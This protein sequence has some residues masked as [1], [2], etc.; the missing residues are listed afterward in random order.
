METGSVVIIF[1]FLIIFCFIVYDSIPSK[2]AKLEES[3]GGFM[4]RSLVRFEYEKSPL[5]TIVYGGTGTGKT[6]FVRQYLQLYSVQNQDPRSGYNDQDQNQNQG[7]NQDQDQNQDQNQ[8]QKQNQNLRSSLVNHEQSSFTD[9]D[10]NIVIVCKDDRDWINP[11]T[12]KFY[13]GF[14]KCDMNMITKNNMQKFRNCVIVLDDMGDKLNKDIDYYFTEGRHYNI[15]MIVM[16]HKPAQINN[17]ARMSCDTIYL[18][19]YNGSDLFKNFNEIYKCEHDFSKII[20]EL[21]SN[22]YNRTDG[23]SDELRYGII[24]YNKKENTF[25]I[26]NSNRTMIY[27]SRVGFLDLKA[28]SLKDELGREDINKLIAY[29]KPLMIN[30]T[31]RNTISHDNYQFYFNKHLTLKGIKI[32]NDVLT[33]EVVKANGLRLFSTILGI[34]SSGL[35]IYNFMSPDITVRNAGHVATAASTMLN[36]TSTLLNYGFGRNQDQDQ[37]L[38]QEREYTDGETWSKTHQ[39]SCYTDGETWTKSYQRSSYTHKYTGILNKEGRENLNSLYVNNEEFRNEIINY[40]KNKMQLNLEAILDK[41]CKTN[42]LNT[43]GNKY[44]AEC[45]KSKD[46]TKDVIEILAKYIC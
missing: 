36:R 24:K 3:F 31:D 32:Q 43:L 5:H 22:H 29:M 45:I 34:I 9:Q 23:M 33:Q 2:Y 13:T 14:N 15:Q 26:I 28:L 12:N 42:I 40:V 10:Q 8:D 39:R 44:L 1:I 16:C 18:T 19:T 20:N 46:N 41:R 27:D 35:M 6:Y 4:N 21:N 7:Q 38:E 30:A 37:D 11:E 17:T 25:I